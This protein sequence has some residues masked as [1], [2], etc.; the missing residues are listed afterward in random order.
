MQV[1][2]ERVLFDETTILRRFDELAGR[3]SNA[4]RNSELTVIAILNGSLIFMADL[5]PAFRFRS[6]SIA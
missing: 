2:L 3:I 6:S 1:D 4:Y 5:L